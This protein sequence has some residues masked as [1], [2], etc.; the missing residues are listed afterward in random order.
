MNL[1]TRLWKLGLPI[2][3]LAIASSSFGGGNH[4]WAHLLHASPSEAQGPTEGTPSSEPITCESF[5]SLLENAAV[6]WLKQE[7]TYF[8]VIV[9]LGD[10]ER[11]HLAKSRLT[12]IRKYLQRYNSKLILTAEGE[13]TK[14]L[15]R[16]ELYV[17]GK[18]QTVISINRNSP[19]V[20]VGR[21]NPF[22]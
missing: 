14:H 4:S 17:G 7:N 11:P 16:V 2:L 19:T 13:R 6:E 10:R 15:G 8:I 5:A 9:R 3:V 21:V 1:V 12:S 18:L 20:C 22:L